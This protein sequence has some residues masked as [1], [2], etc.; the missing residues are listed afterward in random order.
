MWHMGAWVN[1]AEAHRLLPDSSTQLERDLVRAAARA[2]G[3]PTPLRELWDVDTCPERLLPW[4]AWA[5]A[6]QTWESDWPVAVK[7]DRIRAAVVVHRH[8]GTAQSVRRVVESSGGD[9]ALREWWQSDPPG[10]PHTFT[11]T[12]NTGADLPADPAFQNAIIRAIDLTKPVRSHYQ[13]ITGLASTGTIGVIAGARI[14][15]RRRLVLS[16]YAY[17]PAALPAEFSNGAAWITSSGAQLMLYNVDRAE[18]PQS[19]IVPRPAAFS[20]GNAWHTSSG[21]QL[22]FA[23]R[24]A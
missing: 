14:I 21:A 6:L 11:V 13:L 16:G 8:K 2:A 24:S 17:P 7:R 19:P 9:L 20:N 1:N 12:I 3:V 5:L 22:A 23:T 4:L 15:G 10:D 18:A